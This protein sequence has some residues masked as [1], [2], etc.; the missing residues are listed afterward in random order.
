M[1]ANRYVL[2]LQASAGTV[3]SYQKVINEHDGS[4]YPSSLITPLTHPNNLLI[5]HIHI[6][7]YKYIMMRKLRDLSLTTLYGISILHY[8]DYSQLTQTLT[9]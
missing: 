8:L 4:S 9:P 5:S 7:I 6:Y 1:C 3:S 2:F